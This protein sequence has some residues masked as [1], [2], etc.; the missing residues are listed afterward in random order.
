MNRE[1]GRCSEEEKPDGLCDVGMGVQIERARYIMLVA[2]D[3]GV[4]L[5][6]G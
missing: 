3:V 4:K 1:L 2:G 5:R 6:T